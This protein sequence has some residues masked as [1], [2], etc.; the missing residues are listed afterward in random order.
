MGKFCA[1]T[2]NKRL[3]LYRQT[4][5]GLTAGFFVATLQGRSD[6]ISY[7]TDEAKIPLKMLIA[8]NDWNCTSNE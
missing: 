4:V 6:V 1:T 7:V 8:T 3:D 5:T 2:D